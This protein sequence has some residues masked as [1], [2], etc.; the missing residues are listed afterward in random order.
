M[1]KLLLI[2]M[3][4]ASPA[5]AGDPTKGQACEQLALKETYPIAMRRCQDKATPACKRLV[6]EWIAAAVVKKR[7][8]IEKPQGDLVGA[9]PATTDADCDQAF[10][11]DGIFTRG[12]GVCNPDWLERPASHRELGLAK[13][14]A[15]DGDDSLRLLSRGMKDFDHKL[16]EL[17]KPAACTMVDAAMKKVEATIPT[18]YL[19]KLDPDLDKWWNAL[20]EACRGYSGGSAESDL[21]CRQRLALDAL[22]EKKGCQNIYP[23]SGARDTSYWKCKL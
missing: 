15:H 7:A 13:S 1:K 19:D 21:A 5:M 22:I 3:L 6:K 8:C 17:G 14:C 23:A 9:P 16:A 2:L 4:G 10:I 11:M 18:V 20:D 12:S